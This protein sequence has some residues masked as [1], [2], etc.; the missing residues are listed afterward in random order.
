MKRKIFISINIP[1]RDKKRLI[2]ATEKWQNL[3]VKWVREANLHLTLFFLGYVENE[4]IIGISQK[5]RS[6]VSDTDIFDIEFN[7]IEL[8]PSE[9][10]PRLIWLTGEPN[11]D[12]R[13][14]HEK[15]EKDLDIFTASKKSFR[16]HVTL[17][18]VRKHKWEAL[19][20]KPIIQEKLEVFVSVESID[21]MASDFGEGESEYT[22]I[23]SC[24]L[25]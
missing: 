19:E 14:L 11:E 18:R 10:E 8:G 25:R 12:L 5:V 17:G 6:A 20:S 1:D 3:P 15:I 2:K 22:I 24:P 4:D 23:E 21:V 7:N 16:P 13:Q 9:E